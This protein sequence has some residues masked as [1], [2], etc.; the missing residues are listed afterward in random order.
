MRITPAQVL[1]KLAAGTGDYDDGD[2]PGW[3]SLDPDDGTAEVV[4]LPDTDDGPDASQ[5]QRFLVTVVEVPQ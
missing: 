5:Q 1:D 3:L 4:W 2:V